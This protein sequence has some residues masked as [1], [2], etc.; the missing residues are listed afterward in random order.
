MIQCR[1]AQLHSMHARQK[2]ITTIRNI[3]GLINE[4]RIGSPDACKQGTPSH[5]RTWHKGLLIIA[6]CHA[7]IHRF[8]FTGFTHWCRLSNAD[9]LAQGFTQCCRLPCGDLPVLNPP[10]LHQS[11]GHRRLWAQQPLS[12]SFL[13]VQAFFSSL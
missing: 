6:D 1:H 11:L 12:C 13:E 2:V 7:V 5:H 8:G 4:A 9:S 10:E 3:P